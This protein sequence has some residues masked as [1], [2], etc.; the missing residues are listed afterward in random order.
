MRIIATLL[1]ATTIQLTHAQDHH[2]SHHSHDESSSE[3]TAPEGTRFTPT[4]DLRVRMDQLLKLY[5]QLSK[6]KIDA[7]V[8]SDLGTKIQATVNDIFKTC[9]LEPQADAAIHP[10]LGKIL[11]GARDLKSGKTEEGRKKIYES[12]LLYG[13]LF[14]HQGWAP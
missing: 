14:D 11:A 10:A 13:K 7:K 2:H 9:K 1:C 12:L 4:D 3:H 6:N 8:A 5:K